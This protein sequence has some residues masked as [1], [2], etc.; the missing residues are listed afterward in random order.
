MADTNNSVRV[1]SEAAALGQTPQNAGKSSL[2]GPSGLGQ[3]TSKRHRITD[4]SGLEGT[5]GDNLVQTPLKTVQ[6]SKAPLK[7][8]HGAHQKLFFSQQQLPVADE[9]RWLLL[10]QKICY[11]YRISGIILSMPMPSP[12]VSSQLY[13]RSR[14]RKAG[15]SSSSLSRPPSAAAPGEPRSV[16]APSAL[17]ADPELPAGAAAPL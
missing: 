13:T 10:P 5:S 17:R 4:L 6:L 2:Q 8:E 7:T 11:F 9:A 12:P 1:S 15:M 14:L 16:P 3:G